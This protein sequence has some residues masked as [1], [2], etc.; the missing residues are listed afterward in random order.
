MRIIRIQS[1][2]NT[3]YPKPL[4]DLVEDPDPALPLIDQFPQMPLILVDMYNESSNSS[5]D[6]GYDPEGESDMEIKSDA[7][8]VVPDHDLSD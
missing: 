2:N 4:E 6:S 3:L 7:S 1:K 8:D 5:H